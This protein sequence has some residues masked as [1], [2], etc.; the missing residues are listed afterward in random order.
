M[1][2]PKSHAADESSRSVGQVGRGHYWR[3][4]LEIRKYS[5]GTALTTSN[6]TYHIYECYWLE[7]L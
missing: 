3:Y 1:S 4:L 5:Q 7:A 2:Y 6:K